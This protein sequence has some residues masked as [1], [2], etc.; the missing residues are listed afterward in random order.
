M[1]RVSDQA[2]FAAAVAAD[3]ALPFLALA[4]ADGERTRAMLTEARAVLDG[5]PWG[6]GV[7]G[8]APE[9]VRNAQLEAVRELRPTHAIIA[10]GRPAQAEA[11]ERAGIR[12]FLHV[13]SPGLLRQFLQAGRAGSCSRGPSAAGTW[14]RAPPFRCGR[15]NS[16]YWKT[17]W[18]RKPI[19]KPRG[20]WR[21]SSRAGST[22][23]GPRRWSPPWPHP[24][25]PGA[26]PSVSSWA[27][28]TCSP[29]RPWRTARSSRSSSGRS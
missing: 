12:T 11:L 3:G 19:P 23:S 13:P 1:T 10:G 6:V 5:R 18:T 29:R 28:P 9:D 25:P 26:P 24:S 2:A 20:S 7:L 14:D 17:S 27:P 22:T 21:C 8:F 4:L 16:P 15:P